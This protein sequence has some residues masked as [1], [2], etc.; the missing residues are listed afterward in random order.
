MESLDC[1][2]VLNAG[3]VDA[4]LSSVLVLAFF[5]LTKMLVS[6]KYHK[7]GW[8]DLLNTC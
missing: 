5:Y 2:L 7:S 1:S 6:Q 4:F 3:F 8:E